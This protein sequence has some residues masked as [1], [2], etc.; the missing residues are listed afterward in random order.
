MK[1][2][3]VRLT[4]SKYA[5][6]I[7][8]LVHLGLVGLIWAYFEQPWLWSALALASVAHTHYRMTRAAG[9][10]VE[11]HINPQGQLSVARATDAA[12]SGAR[13]LDGSVFTRWVMVLYVQNQHK[14]QVL[15]LLPD[16]IDA[17]AYQQLLVWGRWHPMNEAD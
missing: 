4:P 8:L 14:K 10:L 1:P 16:S 2:I 5:L 13:L 7:N 11:L 6:T 15:W 12:L 17:A 3:H 9:R